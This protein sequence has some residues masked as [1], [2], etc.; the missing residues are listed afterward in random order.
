[1]ITEFSFLGELSFKKLYN[2]AYSKILKILSVKVKIFSIVLKNN[3]SGR[4]NTLS[5]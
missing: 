5:L 2:L 4:R 1:M 3:L